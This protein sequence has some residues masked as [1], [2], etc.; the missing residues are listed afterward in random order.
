MDELIEFI[1]D[2]NEIQFMVSLDYN[3][4]GYQ[5]DQEYYSCY[6]WAGLYTELGAF[7]NDPLILNGDPDHHIWHMFSGTTYSAYAFIDHN[8]VVRYLFDEPNLNDFKYNYIPEL[9]SLMYGCGEIDNICIPGDINFDGSIDIFDIVIMIQIILMEH[10]NIILDMN[11]DN[12][13]DI[14]D[15]IDIL[16]IIL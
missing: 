13:I 6:D 15:I 16:N 10:Y 9:L 2:Y 12:T 3:I 7:D 4:E 5:T 11:S 14:I 1:E 8:M